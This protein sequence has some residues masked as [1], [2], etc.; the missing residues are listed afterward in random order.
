MPPKGSRIRILSLPRRSRKSCCGSLARKGAPW[1]GRQRISDL[2]ISTTKKARQDP[3]FLTAFN[4]RG[5]AGLTGWQKVAWLSHQ[6]LSQSQ[7][8]NDGNQNTIMTIPKPASLR[9]GT[10]ASSRGNRS[11]NEGEGR[12]S[13]AARNVYAGRL[14]VEVQRLRVARL[15]AEGKPTSLAEQLLPTFTKTLELLESCEEQH[16]KIAA[17]CEKRSNITSAKVLERLGLLPAN[18]FGIW[19]PPALT[20]QKPRRLLH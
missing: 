16:R 1:R 3:I 20:K 11:M 9:K 10:T 18:V 6:G 2:P 8:I 13:G 14:I 19:V 5:C 17:A 4:K 12:W 7:L 15:A